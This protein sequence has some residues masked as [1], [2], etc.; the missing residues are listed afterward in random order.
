MIFPISDVSGIRAVLDDWKTALII[1]VKILIPYTV[2]DEGDVLV[3]DQA[4]SSDS[5]DE[6]YPAELLVQYFVGETLWVK[7]PWVFAFFDKDAWHGYLFKAD[8]NGRTDRPEPEWEPYEKMPLDA[9][10]IFVR[11]TDLKVKKLKDVTAEEAV[12][13]GCRESDT[14]LD[15]FK[16]RWEER[17][18]FDTCKN[19]RWAENPWVAV[20]KFDRIPR[21]VIEDEAVKMWLDD[22]ESDEEE[23]RIC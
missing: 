19:C 7:E 4:N 9:A 2:T 20:M 21:E 17:F 23:E 6:W 18:P 12:R 1:P 15:E 5:K 10:R 11:I 16:R 8:W 14:P 3:C 13:A 22:E